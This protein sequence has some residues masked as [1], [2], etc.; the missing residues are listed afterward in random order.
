MTWPA[1]SGKITMALVAVQTPPG[2]DVSA[3]Y[4]GIVVLHPSCTSGNKVLDVS[5]KA[6]VYAYPFSPAFS[7]SPPVVPTSILL[8]GPGE[9]HLEPGTAKISSL[10]VYVGI[11]QRNASL[12]VLLLPKGS[13]LLSVYEVPG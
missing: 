4:F 13:R 3:T 7:V 5:C 6:A 10:V 2:R 1:P 12:E 11:S 8:S 9:F